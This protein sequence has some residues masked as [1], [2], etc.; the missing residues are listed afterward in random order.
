MA[1]RISTTSVGD[2]I[3]RQFFLRQASAEAPDPFAKFAYAVSE[4]EGVS[5]AL[6]FGNGLVSPFFRKKKRIAVSRPCRAMTIAPM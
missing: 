5:V 3:L 4:L 6:G 1:S 2:A